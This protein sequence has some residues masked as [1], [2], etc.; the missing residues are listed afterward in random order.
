MP[1]NAN[2]IDSHLVYPDEIGKVK[3]AE[4]P[5]PAGGIAVE[6]KP[7]LTLASCAISHAPSRSSS[8]AKL[9]RQLDAGDAS[10]S[11]LRAD[12]LHAGERFAVSAGNLSAR[13]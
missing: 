7:A 1:F 4:P 9:S 3:S 2:E 12:R 13:S 10:V 5:H 8:A 6:C 11:S